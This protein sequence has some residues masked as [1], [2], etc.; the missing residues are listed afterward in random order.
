MR[1]MRS[2]T[3]L[4]SCIAL[5]E[6]TVPSWLDAVD[7]LE[8]EGASE[9]RRTDCLGEVLWGKWNALPVGVAMLG[10]E[11]GNMES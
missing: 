9:D 4:S 6:R 5:M 8:T 11:L 2:I 3:M 10:D 1:G 7:Q